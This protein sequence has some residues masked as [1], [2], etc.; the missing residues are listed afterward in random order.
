MIDDSVVYAIAWI[1][2]A[3]AIVHLH[4]WIVQKRERDAFIEEA[5]RRYGIEK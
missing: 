3:A 1:L 2:L 4:H 5:R